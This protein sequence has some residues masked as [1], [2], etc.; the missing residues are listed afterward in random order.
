MNNIDFD[1]RKFYVDSYGNLI[2]KRKQS[3][4]TNEQYRKLIAKSPQPRGKKEK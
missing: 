4:L 1:P 2:P 3:G